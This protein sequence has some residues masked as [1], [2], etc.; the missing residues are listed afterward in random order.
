M[1]YYIID[2]QLTDDL[3]TQLAAQKD[4]LTTQELTQ[5]VGGDELHSE[6]LNFK[7]RMLWSGSGGYSEDADLIDW[8][9]EKDDFTFLKETTPRKCYVYRADKSFK[10]L[11]KYDISWELDARIK[12]VEA[13]EINEAQQEILN[14]HKKALEFVTKA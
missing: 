13:A 9:L 5:W 4:G 11:L 12:K 2:M 1:K 14:R 6:Y 3:A 7:H 10:S 8:Q